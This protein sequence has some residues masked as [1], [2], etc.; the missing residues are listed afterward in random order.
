M[1]THLPSLDLQK[2]FAATQ[3]DARVKIA[4]DSARVE[5]FFNALFKEAPEL[6]REMSVLVVT[7]DAV[8]FLIR[9]RDDHRAAHS[10]AA[11]LR[12]KKTGH[13]YEDRICIYIGPDNRYEP[14]GASL[15]TVLI[16]ELG[17]WLDGAGHLDMKWPNQRQRAECIA[18]VFVGLLRLRADPTNK[19]AVADEMGRVIR[20][21]GGDTQHSGYSVP[22]LARLLATADSLDLSRTTIYGLRD[23]ARDITTK[24]Y[25]QRGR[26][27][28]SIKA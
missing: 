25:Q 22:A 28:P 16:H 7:P 27:A 17:H 18:D 1:T 9:A 6:A 8:G 19:Q 20:A 12:Y 13:I 15:E 24:T 3:S 2:E 26:A 4:A 11:I 23:L 5:A 14:L 21:T 10:D